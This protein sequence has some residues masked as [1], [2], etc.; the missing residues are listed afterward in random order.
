LLLIARDAPAEI[1]RWLEW[2]QVL[3]TLEISLTP[4]PGHS[5]SDRS[6]STV[7]WWSTSVRRTI[8]TSR[9]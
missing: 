3:E 1:I 2:G 4:G 6:S 5:P 9:I 7:N 8:G